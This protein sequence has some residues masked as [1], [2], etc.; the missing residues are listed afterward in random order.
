[1]ITFQ[2]AEFDDLD[3]DLRIAF[4]FG[5]LLVGNIIDNTPTPKS[6]AI[7]LQ[8]SL[9]VVWIFTGG[10]VNYILSLRQLGKKLPTY[11]DYMFVKIMAMA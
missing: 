5:L 9:A 10:I 3:F 7:I 6:M 4:L 2:R 11:V 8:F 1:M